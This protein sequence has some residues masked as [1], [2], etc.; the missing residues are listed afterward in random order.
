M[1]WYSDVSTEIGNMRVACSAKGITMI[2]ASGGDPEVFA[3]NYRVRYGVRPQKGKIPD[4]YR[5][6]VME[7]AAGRVFKAVPLDFSGLTVFQQKVL[8]ILRQVPRGKVRTYAWLARKSGSPGAARAVG[9]TMARNPI[10]FL[11]PCHRIVPA[12]GG[13]GNYG[14]GSK[15]KC[16]LLRREGVGVDQLR[17]ISK[18]R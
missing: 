15:L 18:Q 12:A 13:V 7:A 10:P 9:N 2:D 3:D 11:I 8:K 1:H 6:A 17:Q 14:L 16:E 4:S 5:H